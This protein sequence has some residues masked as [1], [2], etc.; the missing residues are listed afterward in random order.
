MTELIGIGS[1]LVD[2]LLQVEEDFLTEHVEGAKGGMEMVDA[3]GIAALVE[4]HENNPEMAAGGAASNTTLGCANLGIASA[5]IGSCG[6]T[7][8]LRFLRKP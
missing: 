7:I 6:G 3:A 2:Y 8:M 5:F 4:K 1:P